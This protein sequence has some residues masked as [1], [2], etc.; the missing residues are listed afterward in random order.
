M[1]FDEWWSRIADRDPVDHTY[2]GWAK[3][4]WTAALKNQWQTIENC[5]VETDVFCVENGKTFRSV[6]VFD[7]KH[8]YDSDNYIVDDFK[9][10][11]FML[12]PES[13]K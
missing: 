9:P 4:G 8:W 11:H 13:P 5:P 1:S 2:E 6:F 3:L 10:S 7:G 12:I